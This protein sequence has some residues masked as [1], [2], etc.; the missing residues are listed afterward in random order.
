MKYR[1][2]FLC[3]FVNTRMAR[4]AWHPLLDVTAI[5]GTSICPHT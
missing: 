2:T 4:E 5:A 3:F 1:F